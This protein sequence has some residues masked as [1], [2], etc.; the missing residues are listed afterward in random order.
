[1]APIGDRVSGDVRTCAPL[2]Q[3]LRDLRLILRNEG[4]PSLELAGGDRLR[5]HVDPPLTD[6][7][8]RAAARSRIHKEAS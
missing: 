5:V 4:P 2:Q 1:M 3:A 8:R 6:G 7:R